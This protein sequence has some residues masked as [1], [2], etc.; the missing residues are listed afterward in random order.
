ML[1]NF[2]TPYYYYNSLHCSRLYKNSEKTACCTI[3]EH[4]I[5]IIILYTVLDYIKILRKQHVAQF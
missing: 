1:H 5:N 3:L 2:G 4:H